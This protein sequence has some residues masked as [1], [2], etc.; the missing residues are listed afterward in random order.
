MRTMRASIPALAVIA[1]LAGTAHAD[2]PAAPTPKPTP[3]AEEAERQR[4]HW[5]EYQAREKLL[6]E[7]RAAVEAQ[8][9]DLA[10][11][12]DKYPAWARE[13]AGMYY[14][15]DGL[16]MNV[17]I[18]LGPTGDLAYTWYG[19]MGLY[20]SNIGK[21]REAQDDRLVFDLE[22][23]EGGDSGMRYMEEEM[24]LVR[25]GSRRYLV[26]MPDM[27][28]F[29][30]AVNDGWERSRPGLRFA[31]KGTE[32]VRAW[33]EED[34]APPKGLPEVPSSAR[35]WLLAVPIEAEILRVENVRTTPT[36]SAKLVGLQ[37]DVAINAGTD[38]GLR[39]GMVLHVPADSMCVIDLAA[40]GDIESTGT[41][42]GTLYDRG[43]GFTSD[44]LRAGLRC[45]TDRESLR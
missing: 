36:S 34:T 14:C 38:K 45:T 11:N 30:N 29:C 17:A 37:A 24:A 42:R 6:R 4:K 25:W 8:I 16:G 33:S 1:M 40:I 2:E 12:P 19:C 3:T 18:A 41:L 35:R 32:R 43:D 20:D 10:G 26:P 7:K 9:V 22:K 44:F 31:M 5:E 28:D 13:W 15:G 27:Q 23:R 39:Q 21:V